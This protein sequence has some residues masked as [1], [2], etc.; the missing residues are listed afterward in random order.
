MDVDHFLE[1]L[2]K[3]LAQSMEADFVGIL[4]YDDGLK[5]FFWRHVRDPNQVLV[6]KESES[7]L[8]MNRT[9]IE[10]AFQ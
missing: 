5:D 8:R 7:W 4:F 2:T 9:A 6:G 3:E 1:V 10:Q